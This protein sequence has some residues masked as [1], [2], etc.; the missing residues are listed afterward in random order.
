MLKL[1]HCMMKEAIL[2]GEEGYKED[3]YIIPNFAELKSRSVP[4][5]TNFYSI[6]FK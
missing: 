1:K 5:F 6:F 3:K 4:L 2:S